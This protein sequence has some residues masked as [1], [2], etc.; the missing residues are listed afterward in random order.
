[1]TTDPLGLFEDIDQATDRLMDTVRQINDVTAPS[2]LPGW[3][4]GHVLTHVARNADGAANLLTWART[5]VVTPQYES[6]DKREADIEAG[7]DRPVAAQA[8]DLT[9]ACRQ[10][11][12]TV[13][14]MPAEA[15]AQV[16]RTTSGNQLTAAEVMFS[17]LREV[18]IHH[19]D[20]GL[21][22]SPDDWPEA[23]A[24]RMVHILVASYARR[25]DGPRLVIRSPEVGRDLTVGEAVTSPV[26]SGPVRT[27]VAWLIGR[28]DGDRLTV[29]P[30]G[31][32]PVVPV[33]S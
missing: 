2:R 12:A 22:Y 21:G 11:A 24:L 25:E 32:L 18:E 30:P 17:R 14:A 5:G 10:F 8:D 3:T 1:V 31:S 33:W 29:E 23:F 4:V 6:W 28:A 20:L 26:V 7:A 16:V 15:W 13:Q 9:E 19:V 27:V